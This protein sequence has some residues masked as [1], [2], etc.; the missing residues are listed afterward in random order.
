MR[1]YLVLFSCCV[2]SSLLASSIT[3]AAAERAD[4]QT[5]FEQ[6]DANSDN[7]VEP[8]EIPADKQLLFERLLRTSDADE[9]G[10]LSLDEFTSGLRVDRAEKPLVEKAPD[11]LEGADELLLL[12]AM[13]DANGDGIITPQEPP[14]RLQ[15]F[16]EFLRARIGGDNK[17]RINVRQ[18]AQ[19][20]P[21]LVRV[22]QMTVE[23]LEIDVDLEYALLPEENHKLIQRLDRRQR[24]GEALADPQRAVALFQRFDANGDGQLTY[25][26]APDALKDRFDLLLNRADS[27][28]D[29]RISKAELE[30]VSARIRAFN[31][32]RDRLEERQKARDKQRKQAEKKPK[33]QGPAKR[34]DKP[35][36][37]E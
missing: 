29:E 6:L 16:Y 12:L 3:W 24:P 30:R 26:E 28:N 11:R 2:G 32:A 5:M 9:D 15:R 8:D 22:A 20:A 23:R 18:T 4:R 27:N 19:I 7:R 31:R 1:C 25:E 21:Q 10:S 35:A 13:C 37:S 14:Q 34:Q 36:K 33:Q 17:D